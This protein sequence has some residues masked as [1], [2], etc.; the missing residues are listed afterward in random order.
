VALLAVGIVVVL[1]GGV[2][3]AT[4]LAGG[5]A[6]SPEGAVERLFDAIAGE[7]VLGIL[8]AMPPSE[9]NS[10][11]DPLVDFVDELKRLEILSDDADLRSVSGIDL[12]FPE[13]EL[14]SEPITDELAGVRIVRGRAR[15]TT[16]PSRLPV[17]SLLRDLIGDELEAQR[18][19]TEESEAS[20]DEDIIVAVKEDGRW[21]VSLWYT[22]AELSRR[23]AGAPLPDPRERVVARGAA[24]PG[25]AV[26][27]FLRALGAFDIR[28]LFEL[29]PPDEARALHDYAPLF[30]DEAEDG[31]A[32]A[33]RFVD[34]EVQAVES[35]IDQDGSVA[36][37]RLTRFDLDV[38]VPD[39]GLEF[40]VVEGCTEI[41]EGG[42]LQER[43]CAT[44][45]TEVPQILGPFVP[46]APPELDLEQPRTGFVVVRRDGAWYV[47]PTRTLI[48]AVNSVLRVLDRE[49]IE[50]VRDFLEDLFG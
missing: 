14:A 5:G 50:E 23:D 36:L 24:S 41:R 47:S 10:F 46:A 4:Q 1:A 31:L 32:E 33:R 20:G 6:G 42:R 49:D 7:D 27:E 9:R 48:E 2:F 25:A 18:P 45:V 21:Y 43:F 19:T 11:R 37:V 13:L 30:L 34:V 12:D 26:E 3:A 40:R 38:T 29:L 28:R 15:V 17:G 16:D 44:D 22:V 8:E 39:L 35:D